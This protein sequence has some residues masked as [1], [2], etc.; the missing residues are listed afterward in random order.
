MAARKAPGLP[1]SPGLFRHCLRPDDAFSPKWTSSVGHQRPNRVE[2]TAGC[3]ESQLHPSRSVL[4]AMF[5]DSLACL[6]VAIPKATLAQE[7]LPR[8]DSHFKG[9]V[10]S[11]YLDSDAATFPQPVRAPKGAPNVLLILLDD[12]GFGQFSVTGGGVPSPAMEKLAKEGLI[13][14]RFHTTALCSPTR[15]SL[16][17][18]RGPQ[19]S[20]TGIITELATGYDGYTGIIPQETATVAE[21]LRQNGYNTAWIG[22]N[23]NT[24][25]WET[26]AN[27]PFTHWPTGLGFNYFY[28]F[29]AGDHLA[30]GA[31]PRREHESGATIR[32]PQLPSIDRPGRQ[33]DR[34]DPP[35]QGDRAGQAVLRLRRAGGDPFAASRAERVDRQVQGPVRHGLGPLSRDDVRTSEAA[36]RHP[37]ERRA[38][39]APGQSAGLGQRS[40]R[41]SQAVCQNDGRSSPAMAPMSTT[42]WGASSRR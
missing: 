8:A 24:P 4:G 28:G 14:N 6:L 23:H 16:L 38:H 37:G 31:D 40:R 2:L 36:R 22:K 42:K 1:L 27:G 15:A 18:G 3:M 33:G 41:P 5:S 11:T 17:T 19:S 21:V 20:G 35:N 32:E 25:I 34:L 12:V 30:V 26:S 29:N 7:A 39:A 13:Y 9:F 10:G